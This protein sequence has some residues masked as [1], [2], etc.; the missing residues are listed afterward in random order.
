[1]RRTVSLGTVSPWVNISELQMM[2]L[3]ALLLDF[4]IGVV[5]GEGALGTNS[6]YL[7]TNL[8]RLPSL[9]HRS[10]LLYTVQQLEKLPMSA[11]VRRFPL[12]IARR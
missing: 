9:H 7:R 6:L 8:Q 4:Q 2:V 5:G 10:R 11:D 1:M 3:N 12:D